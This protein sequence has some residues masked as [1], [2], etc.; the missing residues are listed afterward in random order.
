MLRAL[1][2]SRRFAPLFWCQ[3]FSALNDNFLK[4]A[5]VALIVYRAASDSPGL[6]V[7]VAGAIL[8]LPFFLLS[9][10]GGQLA[11]RYDKALVARRLKFGEIAVAALAGLGFALH[12]VPL[13]MAALGGF[14]IVAALFGPIKYGI[15]P[16]HLERRELPAGNALIEGAT[17]IAVL[18]GTVTG[19]KA[20]TAESA[21]LLVAGTMLVLAVLCWLASR[22]IPATG[23]AAPE[24]SV[25]PNI[26]R[27]TFRLVSDL[28]RERRLWLGTQAASWFWLTGAVTLAM[29]ATLVKTR[30]GGGEDL[31]VA[32]MLVFSVAIG[33]GSALAARL[34]HGRILLLPGV[35]GAALMGLFAIDL[36][37]GTLALRPGDVPVTPS[38]FLVSVAGVRLAFDLAGMAIAGGLFIVPVFAAV[39]AWAGEDRRA[40]VIAGNNVM[41]AAYIVVGAVAAGLMQAAGWSEPMLFI[42][43]GLLCLLA[44]ALAWRLLPFDA[45]E[46]WRAMRGRTPD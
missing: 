41:N 17:F 35:I 11:D 31:Y 6:L 37:L 18:A 40:R 12:S 10:L 45:A 15:L 38:A 3:F 46:D 28:R 13:L 30:L 9:G 1:M 16:D 24:L 2:S 8:I 23:E 22:A 21:G 25:E 33:L 36:G 34:A 44:A 26:F 43:L 39:Q 27:S 32:C 42:L 5:L 4:N 19:A 20:A 29:L 14:G 7:Q